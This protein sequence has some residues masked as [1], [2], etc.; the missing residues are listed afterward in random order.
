VVNIA[1]R[2]CIPVRIQT[3]GPPNTAAKEDENGS[4]LNHR[5]HRG[6]RGFQALL[7]CFK[8][9]PVIKQNEL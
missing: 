4:F 2:H 9:I 8:S 6:H 3:P 5:E 7:E 1:Y